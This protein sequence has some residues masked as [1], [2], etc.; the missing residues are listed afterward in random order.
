MTIPAAGSALDKRLS[1]ASNGLFYGLPWTSV[2]GKAM[3]ARVPKLGNL[4]PVP[5][6]SPNA[7]KQW[8]E[9]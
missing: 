1:G 6:N 5:S 3:A 2:E 8:W 7:V 9:N 4:F